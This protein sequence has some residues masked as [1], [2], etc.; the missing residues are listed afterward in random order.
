MKLEF[1][2][3]FFSPKIVP[4]EMIMWKNTVEPGRPQMTIWCMCLACQIPNATNTC[5][6][7]VILMAFTLQ[8]WL[9]KHVSLLR[10]TYIIC[11]VYYLRHFSYNG[12][13]CYCLT[14]RAVLQ[15]VSEL[16]CVEGEGLLWLGLNCSSRLIN[17]AASLTQ[18]I[19]IDQLNYCKLGKDDTTMQLSETKQWGTVEPNG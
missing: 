3:Q 17:L 8:Q 2:R 5:S 6:E 15:Q 14:G 1:S 9:C 4:F 11:L 18:R 12:M 13:K 7:C 16:H 19:Y 10:Y